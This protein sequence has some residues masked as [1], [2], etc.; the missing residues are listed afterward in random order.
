MYYSVLDVTLIS[1]DWVSAYVP[2]ASK[3]VTRH[4]GKFLARTTNHEQLEGKRNDVDLR[5]L[6]EWP[7][8]EAA[9]AFM[10]DPEFIPQLKARSEGSISNHY[11]IEG[12][13]TLCDHFD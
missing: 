6:I 9:L 13:T 11:L 4:G 2:I 7:S 8:R 10:N 3:V 1:D 12:K 5:I